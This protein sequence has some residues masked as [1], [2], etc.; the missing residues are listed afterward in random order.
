MH[1]WRALRRFPT[2]SRQRSASVPLRG[3][4]V[5]PAV[6]FGADARARSSWCVPGR[7]AQRNT[8]VPTSFGQVHAAQG[9]ERK[10]RCFFRSTAHPARA[11][12]LCPT[13]AGDSGN[14]GRSAEGEERGEAARRVGGRHPV[15]GGVG[16]LRSPAGDLRSPAANFNVGMRISPKAVDFSASSEPLRVPIVT[17]GPANFRSFQQYHQ[18]TGTPKEH[19]HLRVPVMTSASPTSAH[20]N[21]T[22]DT[23]EL[24]TSTVLLR[25]S[26]QNPLE[27]G[28]GRCGASILDIDT[29]RT[30]FPQKCSKATLLCNTSSALHCLQR[31]GRS[32]RAPT[33]CRT[34]A[35][36]DGAPCDTVRAPSS[37]KE[38]QSTERSPHSQM[39]GCRGRSQLRIHCDP[40]RPVT[41]VWVSLS[42][43]CQS[44]PGG[45]TDAWLRHATGYGAGG[46]GV[47]RAW[48]VTPG[49][50]TP[51]HSQAPISDAT[52]NRVP[53]PYAPRGLPTLLPLCAAPQVSAVAGAGRAE[54]AG[55]QLHSLPLAGCAV[56]RKK[57]RGLRSDPCAACTC[58]NDVGTFVF[59]WALRPGTHHDE[60]ARA[61]AP[62][63]TAGA[64]LHPRNGT[65]ALR[66]RDLRHG[67]PPSGARRTHA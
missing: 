40:L 9:S 52:L 25:K 46:A 56:E 53:A 13:C 34:P 48:P 55:A 16:D 26:R 20:S 54:G 43:R 30:S 39:T 29:R 51:A 28:L 67:R 59:R 5:A 11:L 3:W 57:Q 18:P 2:R 60:R 61:S 6:L 35:R 42:G 4:R 15:K 37:A 62:N 41:S 50:P 7:N 64:T 33:N 63:S 47:A 38:A 14:L 44:V 32:G 24:P 58:P 27:P 19:G 10:P 17:S 65:L 36:G 45:I 8:K 1:P 12:P 21:D 49:Q 66:W 31:L 23:P 22:L